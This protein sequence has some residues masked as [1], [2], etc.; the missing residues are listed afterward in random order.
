MNTARLD[1]SNGQAPRPRRPV[2]IKHLLHLTAAAGLSRA[3]LN[4]LLSALAI[5]LPRG[6]RADGAIALSDYFRILDRL[7][8]ELDDETCRLASKPLIPGA[9]HFAWSTVSDAPDLATAMRR[10]A[11]GYN[12]LHGGH[13]NRVERGEGGLR[14]VIDDRRFPYARGQDAE[15]IVLALE[16][17]LV[18]L[19]GSF[20]LLT[21]DAIGDHLRRIWSRRPAPPSD[22]GA[23]AFLNAPVRWGAP[24]YALVY[25]ER[26]ASLPL[27][28]LAEA[29]PAPRAVYR[30]L[31]R[32][33]AQWERRPL[34]PTCAEQVAQLLGEQPSRRQSA[35]A[36]ALGMSVASLRRRLASEGTSFRAIRTT[37]LMQEAK[38]LLRAGHSLSEI[39]DALDYADFR[40]FSRAFKTATGISPARWRQ[41][42]IATPDDEP[43]CAQ[44]G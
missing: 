14:Y 29:I 1:A 31:V 41:G 11:E 8:L 4:A 28:H 24:V 33:I 27:S 15:Q 38:R 40:S 25:D 42:A 17:V 22:P 19:H 35:V 3:R 7:A 21:E 6:D 44:P 2:P 34:A 20:L 36:R 30:R 13:Y 37:V 43:D 26:A 18:F 23:L 12:M 10:V 5:P 9:T 39:A 16:C 32:R